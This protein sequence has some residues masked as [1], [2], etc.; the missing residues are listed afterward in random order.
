MPLPAAFVASDAE[1]EA[2]CEPDVPPLSS[3]VA[4]LLPVVRD[5]PGWA[6]P[7]GDENEAVVCGVSEGRCGH[8]ASLR[9]GHTCGGSGVSSS[10]VGL[11]GMPD[12]VGPGPTTPTPGWQGIPGWVARPTGD[13]CEVSFETMWCDGCEAK[14]EVK[15]HP[16][17]CHDPTCPSCHAL[18]TAEE[19]DRILARLWFGQQHVK[20]RFWE[21][22]ISPP[23]GA[24]APTRAAVEALLARSYE[25]APEHNASGG[26]AVVHYEMRESPGEWRPHVQMIVYVDGEWLPGPSTER[27][28]IDAEGHWTH[29]VYPDGWTVKFTHM[30]QGKEAVRSKAAYEVGHA[31]R[32]RGHHAVRWFGSASYRQ[33]KNPTKAEL[34]RMGLPQRPEGPVCPVCG[35][36]LR[37]LDWYDLEI[38]EK[39][40]HPPR[41]SGGGRA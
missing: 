32:E 30:G 26:L 3:Y 28:A 35:R 1:W 17:R 2:V 37:A 22:I 8:G 7:G 14:R 31:I 20:G 38:L 29:D 19:A 12:G 4:K 24:V 25:I 36:A 18:W 27:G 11:P 16:H 13:E 10:G 15:R 5:A 39:T 41:L 33:W 23:R 21:L 34:A 6:C 40:G 9:P